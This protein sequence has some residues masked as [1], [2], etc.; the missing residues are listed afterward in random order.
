MKADWDDAPRRVKRGRKDNS[1]LRVMGITGI[2]AGGLVL[3]FLNKGWEPGK[4][5]HFAWNASSNSTPYTDIRQDIAPTMVEPEPP[6]PQPTPESDFWEGV[7]RDREATRRQTSFNDANYTPSTQINI[8]QSVPV[9][10]PQ[11]L[12]SSRQQGLSGSAPATVDWQDARGRRTTW[13]TSFTFHSSR[14]DNRTFCLNVGK[15]SIQ[16]RECRKGAR[17]WL[18]RQCRSSGNMAG[19]WRRMVCHAH[20]SYRT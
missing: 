15:G 10:S 8:I 16:Y 14:I 2:L 19:E 4:I 11:R 12:A 17:E 6:L 5:I 3:V 7:E 18:N 9:N 13:Q 20:S 1:A